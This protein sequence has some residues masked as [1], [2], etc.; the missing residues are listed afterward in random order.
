M[1]DF[2][3]EPKA[4]FPAPEVDLSNMQGTSSG[5]GGAP[6][7]DAAGNGGLGGGNLNQGFGGN[8]GGGKWEGGN[9]GNIGGTTGISDSS[10][11]VADGVPD[12]TTTDT[13]TTPLPTGQLA[14]DDFDAKAVA[15]ET[16]TDP[17][18]PDGATQT[19]QEMIR[20][21]DDTVDI[22]DEKLYMEGA[23]PVANLTPLTPVELE[24]AKVD[25]QKAIDAVGFE[26]A[27]GEAAQSGD[28][29]KFLMGQV[30][31]AIASQM[32]AITGKA[33]QGIAAQV[34]IDQAMANLDSVPAQMQA[35]IAAL[36][37]EALVTT[38][39][40]QLLAGLEG[41]N[42]PL[43]ARP[44][45]EQAEAMMAARGL[46]KST[47]G[48]DALFNAIIGAAMPLA[49]SN[50][51]ALQ[52]RS[53]ENLGYQNAAAQFN[54]EMQQQIKMQLNDAQ[55]KFIGLNAELRQGMELAN[56]DARNKMEMVNLEYMNAAEREN[57]SAEQET[58]LTNLRKE[59][60]VGKQNSQVK[61]QFGMQDLEN[62]QRTSEQNIKVKNDVMF[63]QL[64]TTMLAQEINAKSENEVNMFVEKLNT[65]AEMQF[66]S[67]TADIGK[68]N[69]GLEDSKQKFNSANYTQILSANTS[70]AVKRN[71]FNTAGE[72]AVNATNAQNVF[73]MSM[74]ATAFLNQDYRDLGS[75]ANGESMQAAALTA[76]LLIAKMENRRSDGS[77]AGDFMKNL[78]DILDWVN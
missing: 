63:K 6:I 39:M 18:L 49:Q 41:G 30:P 78:S 13:T 70:A 56:L 47:V 54:A 51:T 33:A 20:T 69:A 24:T 58:R 15:I 22:T 36:P 9:L 57:M 1:V 72:N 76:N 35:V 44:A 27:L 68:F 16:T 50:A 5:G 23:A 21:D 10:E 29:N 48:R 43:W 65:S 42:T 7:V 25:A 77:E 14:T 74:A 45:V 26:A 4:D 71:T 17:T 40:D 34:N 60:E 2:V 73:G 3:E 37:V 53:S 31:D 32:T 64:D 67:I 75:W 46:G 38:Q 12:G 55:T 66:Q 8:G 28:V 52:K 62:R 11:Q 59:V 19:F 61:T